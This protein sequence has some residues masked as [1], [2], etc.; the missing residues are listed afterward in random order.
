MKKIIYFV[1]VALII[2]LFIAPLAKL[3]SVPSLTNYVQIFH[4]ES[5]LGALLKT[6]QVSFWVSV[7]CL[8]LGLPLAWVIS[9]TN[10]P[11]KNL[12]KTLFSLP[13]VIPPFV[14]AIGWII[15]ANP[16]SGILNQWL[17]LKLDIYS[18]WG[19][20]WVESSFLFTF[21]FL[22][23]YSM[24]DKM[25]SSLEEA[26]RL[27]G[28]S[29]AKVFFD[30]SLP[31]LKPALLS[32]FGLVFLATASSFGVPA[33]IGGP[34]RI[35]LLTTQI[36]ALQR[37]GTSN[38]IDMSIAVSSLLGIAT[39]MILFSTAL[40]SSQSKLQTV[41][42]KSNRS[43][44]IELKNKKYF[45]QA[46]LSFLFLII[47]IL[48]LFALFLSA[49]SQT[50]G[51]WSVFKLSFSNFKRVFLETEETLRAIRQSFMLAGG[52]ALICTLFAFFF[53]YFKNRTQF[54]L[55]N[56]FQLLL[57]VPFSMPGTVLSLALIITF[58]RGYFGI[59]PSLY[60]TLWLLLIAYIIKYTS[61]SVKMIDDAYGQIHPSLEESAQVS[62]A[63]W[64]YIMRTIYAPLLKPALIASFFLVLMPVMSELTMTVLL[65]GPG[66]E[67]IGSLIF[68]LQE[69]SDIGGG[70]AA[71]LS[72]FVVVFIL[73][74]NLILKKISQGRYGL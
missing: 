18:I 25:D 5:T 41:G 19:L 13:Y 50:Q 68:H 52:A 28:A 48:P 20:I 7:L 62:G 36:Y 73:T 43:S 59:G 12:W 6:I 57:N 9:R 1:L 35:Y 34:A 22:S 39:L 55:K 60:G 44:L 15:L 63:R 45:V 23:V 64:L 21:V 26:A 16:S 65:T 71:V 4:Q 32:G 47:F 31:L 37:M 14:G 54:A 40:I 8:F 56:I 66:L 72:C 61:L 46:A 38:G 51:E 2:A 10:L 11:S 69:Y 17:G 30:I 27:S 74:L 67:T 42:G 24:L 29:P 49:F 33:L 70:G 53:N 3:F 58:G